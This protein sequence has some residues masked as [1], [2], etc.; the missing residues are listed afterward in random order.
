MTL[1][2][3]AFWFLYLI[4]YSKNLPSNFLFSKLKD[5]FQ[6]NFQK[7]TQ[8]SPRDPD[9]NYKGFLSPCKK[10]IGHMQI[11][12]SYKM[13]ESRIANCGF[14]SPNPSILTPTQKSSSLSFQMGV[15]F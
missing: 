12:L 2:N 7:H 6:K 3:T 14:I 9:L 10:S 4:S 1:F 15:I 5:A 13:W 11:L 8:Q